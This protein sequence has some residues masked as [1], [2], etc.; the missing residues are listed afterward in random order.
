M[1]SGVI[2]SSFAV[3]LAFVSGAS[4]TD[5]TRI[6]RTIA[7]QPHYQGAPKYCLVVFGPDADARVWLVLDGPHLYVDRDGTGDLTLPDKRVRAQKSEGSGQVFKAGTVVASPDRKKHARLTVE[8]YGQTLWITAEFD[9]S[10]RQLAGTAPDPSGNV[11]FADSAA[12]APIVHFGGPLTMR[13]N[14]DSLFRGEKTELFAMI[15]TPGLGPGT[16]ASLDYQ[17][18]P[19]T[20]EPL[21]EVEIPSRGKGESIKQR[22]VLE[23]RC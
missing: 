7:K 12:H 22:V 8:Q 10:R 3:L 1:R 15:G 4:A 6:D 9:D 20:V 5:L 2:A 23:H 14:G 18:V 17:C 11:Q 16:F 13:T 19:A 21:A